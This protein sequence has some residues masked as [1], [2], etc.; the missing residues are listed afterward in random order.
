MFGVTDELSLDVLNPVTSKKPHTAHLWGK[1]CHSKNT[2]DGLI[3]SFNRPAA[4]LAQDNPVDQALVRGTILV[5]AS[6]LDKVF[7]PQLSSQLESISKLSFPDDS[8]LVDEIIQDVDCEF[9]TNSPS[10]CLARHRGRD[11]RCEVQWSRHRS[12]QVLGT[13]KYRSQVAADQ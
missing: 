11:Y 8:P 6:N 1:R 13:C 7:I 5:K 9:D 4:A 12:L 10:Q 2:Y 3:I